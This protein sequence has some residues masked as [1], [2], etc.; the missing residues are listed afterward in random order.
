MIN[1]NFKNLLCYL[2]IFLEKRKYC[3]VFFINILVLNSNIYVLGVGDTGDVLSMRPTKAYKEF[4]VP[5]LALYA[6]PENLE[7]YKVD[8]SKPKVEN[9]YSSPYVQRVSI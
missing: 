3:S 5:G 1:N 9:I 7:K 4:L 8:E 6:T 2:N